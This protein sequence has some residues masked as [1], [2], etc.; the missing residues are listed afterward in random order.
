[1]LLKL[2]DN[3]QSTYVIE[4]NYMFLLHI[5]IPLPLMVYYYHNPIYSGSHTDI[6]HTFPSTLG[7]LNNMKES[8]W[9]EGKNN[10]MQKKEK[11]TIHS[12]TNVRG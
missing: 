12:F 8:E 9:F 3:N 2:G 5:M 11:I 7:S 4:E 1:M 10:K 6:M